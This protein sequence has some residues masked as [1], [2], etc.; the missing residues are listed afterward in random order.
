MSDR[1][2]AFLTRRPP[3]QTIEWAATAIGD[4]ARVTSVR[5][6]RGGTSSAVH[7]LTIEDARGQ[8]E[9]FVLRRFVR[10][11]WLALEPDLAAH[12]AAALRL[13]ERHD[14]PAPR[15]VAFD[16][17]A[18]QTD[19]PAVLMTYLNGRVEFAPA[20]FDGYL[21]GMAAVLPRIHA[22]DASSAGLPPYRRYYSSP[23]MP[24]VTG[25]PAAWRALISRAAESPPP[26]QPAFI[27]RDY[28]PGNVLW[29]RRRVR[30]VIDWV[31][32]CIGPPEVDAGHCR[33]N[34]ATLFGVE[35][36]DAFLEA[37]LAETGAGSHDPY[38][39]IVCLLDIGPSDEALLGWRDAGR[40]DLTLE[41]LR[42]RRDAY[43]VSL[44]RRL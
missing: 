42:Q 4:G 20:D 27:H 16:D 5:R 28:H 2:P 33:W 19:V 14:L 17:T 15:L 1:L 40:T 8:R 21:R 39:D 12:E 32:A 26:Y 35:A 23:S 7:A 30:G 43:A 11:D 10:A 31:N 29:S 18:E 25:E 37:W 41:L 38:W 9:R 44:A 3:L 24:A 6:L 34:L 22:I 13:L 36:A